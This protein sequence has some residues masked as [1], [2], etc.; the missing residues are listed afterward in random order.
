MPEREYATDWISQVKGTYLVRGVP[1]PPVVPASV[2]LGA[3]SAAAA[4]DPAFRGLLKGRITLQP[5]ENRWVVQ[6]YR[7]SDGY[8]S[9][10]PVQ[11]LVRPDQTFDID[12]SDVDPGPGSWQF[13]LLDALKGYSPVGV[14]WPSTGTYSGWEIKSFATTDRLYLIDTQSAS[15]DGTFS[16]DSTA[17]G[18]KSFQLVATAVGDNDSPEKVLAEY[19]PMTGLVRSF[20]AQSDS[21]AVDGPTANSYSYD[22]ALALQTALV[23]DDLPTARVLGS[24]IDV[25]ADNVGTTSR[26]FHLQLEAVEPGCRGT[27]LSHRQYRRGV[28]FVAELPQPQRAIGSA[29]AGAPNGR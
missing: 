4:T 13:G 23:M 29:G 5:Q 1:R 27:G 20:A 9:R 12:V 16:F 17:P 15:V 26:R 24:R 8:R 7:M 21:G 22:Q 10:V 14:P 18:A 11:S 28:V 2:A 19:A 25:A 6:A 3:Q